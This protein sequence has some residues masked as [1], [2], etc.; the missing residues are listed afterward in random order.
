[1]LNE[2]KAAEKKKEAEKKAAGTSKGKG[3]GKNSGKKAP[4]R[5]QKRAMPDE[6]EGH[7]EVDEIYGDGGGDEQESI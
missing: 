4:A 3:K 7:D 6:V 1:M 2:Q 5:V